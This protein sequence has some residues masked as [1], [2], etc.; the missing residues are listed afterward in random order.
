MSAAVQL[1][2]DIKIKLSVVKGPHLGQ[3][4]QL[5]KTIFTIGRG[6][7][8]DIILMNDPLI[9]RTHAQLAVVDRDLEISNLNNK[10]SILVQGT[11]V[12]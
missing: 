2:S 12:Q 1:R 5:N 6:P 10:N 11:S 9:S 3:V 4:F 8:N 7:E